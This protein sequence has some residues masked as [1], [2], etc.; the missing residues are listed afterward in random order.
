MTWIKV[1][2][3]NLLK[4]FWGKEFVPRGLLELHEYFKNYGAIKFQFKQED[5]LIIAVSENFQYGSIVTS[6][7]DF[8]ELDRNIKDAI[9]TSFEIPSSYTTEA[10][11]K[12]MGEK[13]EEYVLA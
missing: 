10:N 8:E 3:N 5:G 11:I 2:K 4:S 13:R 6:G 12:R 7:K 1:I 9:L